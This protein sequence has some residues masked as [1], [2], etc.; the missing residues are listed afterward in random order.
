MTP[1]P[2]LDLTLAQTFAW[3]AKHHGEKGLRDVLSEEMHDLACSR[4]GIQRKYPVGW[5]E[6]HKEAAAELEAL[7]LDNIARI[8][9]EYAETLPSLHDEQISCPYIKP[10]YVNRPGNEAN[11]K[12]WRASKARNSRKAS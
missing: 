4:K 10:P 9:A 8:I 7:G 5:R 1:N 6:S 12:A 3:V 11:L 2:F